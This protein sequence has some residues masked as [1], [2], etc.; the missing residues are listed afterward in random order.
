MDQLV[1]EVLWNRLISVVATGSAL[2]RTRSPR[3][4]ARRAT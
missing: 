1:L 2:M 3:L 4:C